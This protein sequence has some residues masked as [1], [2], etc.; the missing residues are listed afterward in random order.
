MKEKLF[1]AIVDL[2]LWAYVVIN[3]FAKN[4]DQAIT[5]LLVLIIHELYR[6]NDHL[7]GK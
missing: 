7:K 3:M 1:M 5:G 2:L 6:V 4:Y